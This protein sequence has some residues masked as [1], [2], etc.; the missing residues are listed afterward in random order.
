MVEIRDLIRYSLVEADFDNLKIEV[1]P[2]QF[3]LT[4]EEKMAL[5]DEVSVYINRNRIARGESTSFSR[6]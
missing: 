3:C 5:R 2:E 4:E 6:L 1:D